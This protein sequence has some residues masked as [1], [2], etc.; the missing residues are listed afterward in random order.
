MTALLQVLGAAFVL[1]IVIS[2]GVAIA[3]HVRAKNQAKRF[4]K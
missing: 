1:W 3:H 4:T 2:V